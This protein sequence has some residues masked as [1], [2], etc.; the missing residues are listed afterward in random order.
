MSIDEHDVRLFRESLGRIA[1]TADFQRRFY[2]RFIC[3]SPEIAQFFRNRDMGR[4]QSKLR[5]TLE[6]VRGNAADQPGLEMYLGL[7]GRIH[8]GLKISGAHF[9][10][11]RKAAVATVAECDP[12]ADPSILS[13]WERV[14]DNLIAKMACP[15]TP[16]RSPGPEAHDA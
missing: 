12:Q 6:M 5:M 10:L 13:A 9:A 1:G 16:D 2:E 8:T 14:I 11:W 3:A 4:I 15:E 7:L